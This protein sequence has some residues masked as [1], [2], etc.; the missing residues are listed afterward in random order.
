[1]LLYEEENEDKRVYQKI[2]IMVSI[3]YKKKKKIMSDYKPQTKHMYGNEFIFPIKIT[4]TPHLHTSPEI[5]FLIITCILCEY[6]N[7]IYSKLI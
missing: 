7:T 5:L 2:K 6:T 4:H 3:H 1:M